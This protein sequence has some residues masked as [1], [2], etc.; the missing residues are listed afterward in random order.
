MNDLEKELMLNGIQQ[1][2]KGQDR[3]IELQAG[4]NDRL[5]HLDD[6]VDDAKE[7][8]KDLENKLMS[9]FPGGDPVS[10][11]TYHEGVMLARTNWQKLKN[12][13]LAEVLKYG[14]VF[15]AGWVCLTLWGGFK[16]VVAQ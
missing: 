13:V 8:I 16:I 12:S 11:R 14:V 7:A 15:V 4:T 3:M 10:H 2:Q 9:A 6:C 5:D 1:L